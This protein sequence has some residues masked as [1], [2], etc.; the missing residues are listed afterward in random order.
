MEGPIFEVVTGQILL[1]RRAEFERLHR[2]ILIP[3]MRRAGIEPFLLLVTELGAYGKFVNI[4]KYPD[5]RE[6]ERRTDALLGDS[7]MQRFYGDIAQC[8]HGSISIEIAVPFAHA[9]DLTEP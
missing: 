9:R 2:D 5:L 7:N 4:Y 8:I 3:M 6:Y 1:S